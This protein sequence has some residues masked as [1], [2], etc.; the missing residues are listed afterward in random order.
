M[1]GNNSTKVTIVL[2]KCSN[3]EAF[4][5]RAVMQKCGDIDD[6]ISTTEAAELEAKLD[7]EVVDNLPLPGQ[8]DFINGGPPC[9]VSWV[10]FIDS[11]TWG[12]LLQ[13]ILTGDFLSF[14]VSLG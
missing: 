2:S 10:I 5:C 4:S 6:C 13:R 12:S 11:L 1:H 7:K 3:P 9:Q 8:V 14:R